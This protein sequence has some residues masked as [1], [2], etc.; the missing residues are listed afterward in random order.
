MESLAKTLIVTGAV[1]ALIGILLYAG[2]R[3]GF[4]GLGR[5][6]GDIRVEREN[7]KLFFPITTSILVSI[8]LSLL[9]Y[10]ASRFRG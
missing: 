1:I 2:S 7:F 4:M 6:P 9:F 5:L 3:L 10:L 8:L